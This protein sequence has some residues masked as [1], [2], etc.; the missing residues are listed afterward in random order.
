M[1]VLRMN[2]P[3]CL[4][5]AR[6]RMA[7]VVHF[8]AIGSVQSFMMYNSLPQLARSDTLACWNPKANNWQ[9][10]ILWHVGTQRKVQ[11]WSIN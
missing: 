10:R 2:K 4:T 3:L 9:D 1:H 7:E 11:A 5:Q 6:P 8:L